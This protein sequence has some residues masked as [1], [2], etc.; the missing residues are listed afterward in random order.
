[1]WSHSV[2]TSRPGIFSAI[3]TLRFKTKHGAGTPP[4]AMET[5]HTRFVICLFKDLIP[6]TT[7]CWG[8]RFSRAR[9]CSLGGWSY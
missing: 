4:V 8:R 2:V 1:M 5:A 9:A 6:I 7:D 3:C